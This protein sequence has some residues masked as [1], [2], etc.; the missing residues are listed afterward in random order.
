MPTTPR[1][2][3]RVLPARAFWPVAALVICCTTS[4]NAASPLLPYYRSHLHL[5]A[6]ATSTIFAG[7]PLGALA[8]AIPCTVLARRVGPKTALTASTALFAFATCAFALAHNTE[9]LVSARTAQGAIATQIWITGLTYL[10]AVNPESSRARVIG[11]MVGAASATVSALSSP[12]LPFVGLAAACL[13]IA[14]ALPGLP[15][16][17]P[18]AAGPARQSLRTAIKT[19]PPLRMGLW[20]TLLAA[21]LFG[22]L[23]VLAPLQ[24]AALGARPIL[25]GGT[26]LADA[27]L[28]TITGPIS[29]QLAARRHPTSVA[30]VAICAALPML[31]ALPLAPSPWILAACI[32]LASIAFNAVVTPAQTLVSLGFAKAGLSQASAFGVTDLLWSAGLIL[33]S[34]GG[35]ATAQATRTFVPYIADLCLCALTIALLTR[36]RRRPE[37][38]AS[39]T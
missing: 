32:P 28:C 38:K 7:Y 25:I 8:A 13:L 27:A 34:T 16:V 33:G 29:G 15:A 18:T 19:Q 4:E 24:L 1:V 22:G 26:F 36:S 39:A 23:N 11:L 5:S 6:T 20:L 9:L 10:T 2:S 35:A 14:P 31:L 17:P 21:V 30:L 3:T 12:L 37:P